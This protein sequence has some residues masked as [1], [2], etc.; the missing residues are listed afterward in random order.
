MPLSM[1][2]SWTESLAYLKHIMGLCWCLWADPHHL[3]KVKH[4]CSCN[5]LVQHSFVAKYHM[6]F[7]GR[8]FY[9]YLDNT[10]FPSPKLEQLRTFFL[11][12]F[13][14]FPT[15]YHWK[16]FWKLYAKV[17]PSPP[18]FF[19]ASFIIRALSLLLFR[20]VAKLWSNTLQELHFDRSHSYS[21]KIVIAIPLGHCRS[22]SLTS[23]F[24]ASVSTQTLI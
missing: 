17:V 24:E 23:N 22:N 5:L 3:G 11:S 7:F 21:A 2:L 14:H 19:L 10:C 8:S 4:L 12:F 1:L 13:F 15:S 16:W 18:F 9:L 20:H 6:Y